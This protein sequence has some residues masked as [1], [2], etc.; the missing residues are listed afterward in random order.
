MERMDEQAKKKAEVEPKR[1]REF[2][3]TPGMCGFKVKIGCSEAYFSTAPQLSDAIAEYLFDPQGTTDK[4]IS[5][6]IRLL[7]I[8]AGGADIPQP[9]LNV[10]QERL[11]VS[12]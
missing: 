5:G 12:R 3:V 1:Y 10:A 2:T 7:S 9:P 4:M 6:D 11:G 8:P